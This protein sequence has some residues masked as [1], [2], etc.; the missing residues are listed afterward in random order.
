MKRLMILLLSLLLALSLAACGATKYAG[1]DSAS[2]EESY[3]GSA[4]P[5]VEYDYTASDDGAWDGGVQTGAAAGGSLAER[6]VKMVYTA[7]IELQ[8]LE[9][10]QAAKDIAALV[11]SSGGYFEQKN[12]SNYSSGY[13]HASYTV[14]VPA[15]QFAAF[16][17]QVGTL[18]HMTWRSDTAENISEQYYDTQ[19][20]LETA[21][22]KLER[23]Q[24]LLK[25]AESMEDII[26]IESAISETE[27]EIEELSGAMRHYDALV[28]YATVTLELS[29]VY[30]LSGTEDAPRTFGEKLGSA[31]SDG[32]SAT[33]QALEDLAV[34]LAYSWLGLLIFAAAVF[35]V[36]KL[37]L[38]LR[39]S[40]K[41]SQ[42]G[43]KKRAAGAPANE[44]KPEE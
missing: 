5:D 4:L 36:V 10:D 8:T 6:G 12:F 22:I 44:T 35:G 39:R 32:L 17:D 28:D 3:N 21:Q 24:E 38:R 41:L 31:F 2:T 9:F 18:C 25:K 19:A 1:Y 14:R 27:Y 43:R 29:E 42:P 15:E 20:R 37:I 11:E 33:G 34:W 30:R 7:S 13:R 23:L 40:G 16:C 26:T